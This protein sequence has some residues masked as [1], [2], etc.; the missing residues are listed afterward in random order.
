MHMHRKGYTFGSVA[1]AKII[2]QTVWRVGRRKAE[3][4]HDSGAIRIIVETYF[5]P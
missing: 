2:V 4:A 3:E 5:Q 1:N